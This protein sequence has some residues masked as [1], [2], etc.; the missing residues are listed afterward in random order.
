MVDAEPMKT[1]RR[2]TKNDSN[3]TGV[4]KSKLLPRTSNLKT[5]FS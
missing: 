5:K 1:S 4:A 3:R 2:V